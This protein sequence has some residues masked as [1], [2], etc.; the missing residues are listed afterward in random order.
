LLEINYH[1]IS[2]FRDLKRD[3]N[4]PST[5]RF[6]GKV[7][8]GTP[9]KYLWSPLNCAINLQVDVVKSAAV[10][11]PVGTVY[12]VKNSIQRFFRKLT[13][14]INGSYR[15]MGNKG[16]DGYMVFNKPK[17][18]PGDTVKL[19]AF[20]LDSKERPI[21]KTMDVVLRVERK[22]LR[23]GTIEPNHPGAYSFQFA[24]HD[25]LKLKLDTNYEVSLRAK[26]KTKA[27]YRSFKYEDYELRKINL[28]LRTSA[29]KHYY[30][31]PFTC[32][33]KGTDVNGLNLMDARLE[34]TATTESVGKGFADNVFVPDTLWKKSLPL[35]A[36]GETTVDLVD[37][38][39]PNANI[40]Y[41]FTARLMTSDNQTAEQSQ[42]ISYFRSEQS[43]DVAMRQG[44]ISFTF[45]DNGEEKSVKAKIYSEDH[46]GHSK[47]VWEGTTPGNFKL[48]ATVATYRFETQG[49]TYWHKVASQPS[50]LK[51]FASR[52]ADSLF[53]DVQNPHNIPFV[54]HLYA[55]NN[56]KE[57]AYTDSLNMAI[58]V[59]SKRTYYCSVRYIWGGS[60]VNDTYRIPFNDKL[61]T[62]A[63]DQPALVFPGQ[64]TTLGVTV[65]DAKGKPAQG[66]DLMAW[67]LTQKF[68]YRAPS[69]PNTSK[70]RKEKAL[71]NNFKLADCKLGNHRGLSLDYE[72]WR[73][74][75]GIDSVE[76]Y[77]FLYP[78]QQIVPFRIQ[79]SPSKNTDC[80]FC[81]EQRRVAAHSRYLH[82]QQ[83]GLFQLDQ[84]HATLLISGYR[85]RPSHKTAN[86]QQNN[87]TEKRF[88]RTWQTPYYLR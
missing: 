83:T 33:L 8:Y 30:G 41:K 45:Q 54:Y 86:R 20:V 67:G 58:K 17:Y 47:L 77:K 78:G 74:L 22:D 56:E 52:Q 87:R 84:P 7:F 37:S 82:R 48:N 19:K 5:K 14:R 57:R 42:T 2:I 43:F 60:V 36:S 71:I 40:I 70:K 46:Y 38:L 88:N 63:L 80:P 66:V 26:D 51:C 69:L 49:F 62:V 55:T 10:Q 76:Y 1:G 35:K 73:I 32:T 3:Q 6:F 24:L 50:Q 61:L 12:T 29:N 53:V 15:Y 75:S 72:A 18:L 39:F 25:S 9:L 34:L 4:N 64:T 44:D 21:D 59:D 11:R 65:T 16:N 28:N 68:D 23:L 27:I 13:Q 81:G 85:Q 31:K 79:N